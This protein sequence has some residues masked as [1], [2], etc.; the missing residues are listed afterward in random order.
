[1]II[2]VT[3]AGG[4]IGFALVSALLDAGYS[5]IPL[6][7]IGKGKSSTLRNVKEIDVATGVGLARD[8]RGRTR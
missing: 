5:V 6:V 4:F 3:G 1:M 2:A 7:R 8:S